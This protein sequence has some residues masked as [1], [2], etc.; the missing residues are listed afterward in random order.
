MVP[1]GAVYC[2]PCCLEQGNDCYR[3]GL[4]SYNE[5]LLPSFPPLLLLVLFNCSGY[6]SGSLKFLSKVY[7]FLF[8]WCSYLRNGN[9]I[10][11]LALRN[12]NEW[13]RDTKSLCSKEFS[14]RFIN[15]TRLSKPTSISIVAQAEKLIATSF[16]LGSLGLSC[17]GSPFCLFCLRRDFEIHSFAISGYPA[18]NYKACLTDSW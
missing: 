13:L 5:T 17:G 14:G 11:S 16:M 3:T 9:T 2:W 7:S 4:Y 1:D 18:C 15:G 12:W 6:W 10:A 8:N